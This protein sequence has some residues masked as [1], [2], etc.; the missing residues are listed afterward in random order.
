MEEQME[1]KIFEGESGNIYQIMHGWF[2][3]EDKE[4]YFFSWMNESTKG[5]SCIIPKRI[6]IKKWN[7][8][9]ISSLMSHQSSDTE[10]RELLSFIE[11]EFSK[12]IDSN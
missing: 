9:H 12:K 1:E 4:Y 5:N 8:F 6:K 2:T 11:R 10:S 7:H 3:R